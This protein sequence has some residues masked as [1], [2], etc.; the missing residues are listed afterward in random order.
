MSICT[1]FGHSDCSNEIREELLKTINELIKEENVDKFYV[2]NNGFFDQLVISVL[3]EIKTENININFFVVLSQMPSVKN[4]FIINHY[5][6]IL[7]DGIEYVYPKFAII[8]RNKWMVKKSDFVITYIN[9]PQGG[10]ARFYEY[11][12]K[13]GKNVINLGSY[14]K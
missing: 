11:A 9:H 3:D 2:G 6:T 14:I 4:H 8:Y 1:F 7:P 12:I 10:A 5:D 13:Q